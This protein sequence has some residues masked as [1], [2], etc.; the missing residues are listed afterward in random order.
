MALSLLLAL[1]ALL[2]VAAGALFVVS[3]SYGEAAVYQ[4][5][6]ASVYGAESGAN[7]GLGYVKS[8]A[9]EDRDVSFTEDGIR[10]NAHVNFST[11]KIR[12]TACDSAGKNRRYLIL[13]FTQG[14]EDGNPVVTVTKVSTNGNDYNSN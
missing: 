2:T 8:G 5:G 3:R 6:L 14:E 7:W 13:W 12:S 9:K 11:G 1:T 10:V 4:N